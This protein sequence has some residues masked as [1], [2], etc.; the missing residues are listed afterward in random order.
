LLLKKKLDSF[1]VK[2]V[3]F[4]ILFLRGQKVLVLANIYKVQVPVL[5][6]ARKKPSERKRSVKSFQLK[7]LQKKSIFKSFLLAKSYPQKVI[8]FRERKR[9][10][11]KASAFALRFISFSAERFL[12]KL[13]LSPVEVKLKNIFG[14]KKERVKTSQIVGL[15]RRVYKRTKSF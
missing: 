4:K 3:F 14:L 8:V 13:L 2:I 6:S 5:S 10:L 15:C 12:E 7:S 1:F 9:G 11:F